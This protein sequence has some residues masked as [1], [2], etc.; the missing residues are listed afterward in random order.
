MGGWGQKQL[1]V[2]PGGDVL[3]CH[4]A[5]TIPGLV[6]QRA[7]E[8][9]LRDIWNTGPAFQAFR[10]TSWM[11]EPC[12]SCAFKDVDFGGCRCQALALSGDARAADPACHRSHDHGAMQRLADDEAASGKTTF[13]YRCYAPQQR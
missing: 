4:A 10:G 9:T 7:G 11:R 8:H 6:F 12:T 5:A 2:T 3:P 13:A 1:L